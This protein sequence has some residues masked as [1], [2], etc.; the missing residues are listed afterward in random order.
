MA[1]LFVVNLKEPN[2]EVKRISPDDGLAGGPQ[3]QAIV[4][5]IL[6]DYAHVFGEIPP[7][8]N[9]SFLEG[10][11]IETE[12]GATPPCRPYYR[13]SAKERAEL[14]KQLTDLL[15]S[16]WIRPSKSPYGSPILCAQA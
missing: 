9:Y 4:D 2:H 12:P 14:E 11:R 7:G 8:I 6:A 1:Q 10:H 3:T 15:E 13:M 16:G 5:A